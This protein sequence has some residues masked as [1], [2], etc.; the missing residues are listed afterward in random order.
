MKKIL[1]ARSLMLLI[2]LLFPSLLYVVLSTGSHNFIKRPVYGPKVLSADGDS[3]YYKLSGLSFDDC[4]SQQIEL[5]SFQNSIILYHFI[6]NKDSVLE[7]R[8]A[9]QLIAL[10]DRFKEKKDIKIVSIV[11]GEASQVCHFQREYE[12]ASDQWQVVGFNSDKEMLREKFILNIPEELKENQWTNLFV[13][14]DNKGRVRTYRD[15][16]QY[17]EEKALID[18]IKILKAEEFI[19]KK[20]KKKDA[21]E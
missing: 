8:K 5:S 15:A 11:L 7:K 10:H 2:I 4:N 13:L 3:I 17:V 12:L 16:V 19:P 1:N 21:A 6:E 18:D 9:S 14:V 20:K